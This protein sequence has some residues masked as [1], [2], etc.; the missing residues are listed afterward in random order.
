M[1]SYFDYVYKNYYPQIV[2]STI[3]KDLANSFN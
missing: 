2:Y 1:D 3:Y